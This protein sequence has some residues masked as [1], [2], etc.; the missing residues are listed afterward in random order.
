ML[1]GDFREAAANFE[2]ALTYTPESLAVRVNLTECYKR[3]V[4]AKE[5][6]VPLT[7]SE[8]LDSEKYLF[9][10]GYVQEW[11]VGQWEQS[12]KNRE[13]T[14]DAPVDSEHLKASGQFVTIQSRSAIVFVKGARGP[15]GGVVT[16]AYT[17]V[18]VPETQWVRLGLM[19]QGGASM[20]INGERVYEKEGGKVLWVG[21]QDEIAGVLR[22]GWN[23]LLLKLEYWGGRKNGFAVRIRSEEGEILSGLKVMARAAAEL[24]G[25]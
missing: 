25:K 23:E 6:I 2:K 24:E 13:R 7:G 10:G 16:Y 18:F 9:D 12:G 14:P 4:K 15:L 22:K 5:N 21:D 17:S 8:E 19:A 20:W 3:G 1:S 11:L